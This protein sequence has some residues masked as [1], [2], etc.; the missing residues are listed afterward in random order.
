VELTIELVSMHLLPLQSFLDGHDGRQVGHLL[1][2]AEK[3][4]IDGDDFLDLLQAAV[5]LDQV[6]GSRVGTHDRVE[7]QHLINFF[8]AEHDFAPARRLEKQKRRLELEKKREQKVFQAVGL[9]GDSVMSLLQMKPGKELGQFL[10]N[11][12]A[13][14]RGEKDFPVVAMGL[15]KELKRRVRAAAESLHTV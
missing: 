7:T 2:Y 4:G 6:L 12:Y 13:A 9:D 14:V 1:H 8:R 5:F 11:L 3:R 15:E 10:Q